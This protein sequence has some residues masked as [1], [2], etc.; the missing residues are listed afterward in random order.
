MIGSI[1]QLLTSGMQQV[2]GQLTNTNTEPV[3]NTTTVKLYPENREYNILAD[4][5][6]YNSKWDIIA[7]MDIPEAGGIIYATR[8]FK[9][10]ILYKD[11][12]RLQ[13]AIDFGYLITP[14]PEHEHESKKIYL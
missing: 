3:A 7:G 12:L 10:Q 9:R 6:L 5:Y 8:R 13:P 11:I 2:A 1:S 14:A 4:S